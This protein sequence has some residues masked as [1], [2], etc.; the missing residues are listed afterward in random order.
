MGAGA[1][2]GAP[3]AIGLLATA[4]LL[5]IVFV[6]LAVGLLGSAVGLSARV[7]PVPVAAMVAMTVLAPLAA[8]VLVHRL[9]PALAERLAKP[10]SLVASVL[11]VVGVLA[12]L[13][14]AMPAIILLMGNGTLAAIV[15]FVLVGL[16]VGHVLGGPDPADRTVLALM[17]ASRHPGVAITIASASFPERK[18]IVAAILLYLLVNAILYLPYRAWCRR[19]QTGG[20]ERRPD[21]DSGVSADDGPGD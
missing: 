5:A 14:V 1:A 12:V 19:H 10:V 7:S 11:L 6:P 18:P 20:G 8:G 13:L 16:A 9:A 15:A 21:R 4:A 3:Y 2:A 17:T